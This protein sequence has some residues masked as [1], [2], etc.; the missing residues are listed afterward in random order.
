MRHVCLHDNE[1]N[2]LAGAQVEQAEIVSFYR[3][4]TSAREKS[5][6]KALLK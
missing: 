1:I 2:P 6:E 3:K 4:N 5:A